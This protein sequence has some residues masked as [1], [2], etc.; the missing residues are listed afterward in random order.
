MRGIQERVND[1][2]VQS[3]D[4]TQR[5]RVVRD[6]KT[7]VEQAVAD[8]QTQEGQQ[9]GRIAE[10]SKDAAQAWKWIQ[11]HRDEFEEEIYAPAV[12]SCAIRKEFS[13]YTAHVE[14]SLGYKDFLAFTTQTRNDSKKLSDQ[15]NGKMELADITIRTIE[16]P[17]AELKHPPMSL[18]E[19]RRCGLDGWAFDYIDGPEPVLAMLCNNSRINA[20]GISIK[21]VTEAQH[22]LLVNG[23]C[24]SWVAGNT[25]YRVNSRKDYGAHA[26]STATK[27]IGRARFWTQDHAVDSSLSREAKAKIEEMDAEF[28]ELKQ[29]VLPIRA[30]ITIFEKQIRELKGDV[31]SQS[32]T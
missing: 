19:M 11:D 2:K 30:E 18:E 14:T 17:L 4:L 27:S 1:L 5:G 25:S 22:E 32:G 6:K 9:V 16:K 26:T 8:S 7:A 12:I 29:K 28:E 3:A 15:L 21:E 10:F 24:N 23:A 20:T 31:V 13:H